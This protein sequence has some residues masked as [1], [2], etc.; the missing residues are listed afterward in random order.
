MLVDLKKKLKKIKLV[1][2]DFDG[3]LT[4][5]G[6]VIFREDGKESV[7]CS[8]RDSLGINMLQKNGIDVIVISK[9]IN[10]VVAKRCEKMKIKCWSGVNTG[11]NKLEILQSY[12]KERGFKVDEVCY[13]GDDVNDVPCL[14]WAGVGFTV[15]DGH[16][17]SKKAAQLVTKA[18]GGDGAVREVCEL[19]LKSQK[20]PISM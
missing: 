15:A 14:T 16:A 5:R 1:A 12:I 4:Y 19:I 11:D 3:V 17:L 18:K 2:L 20:K 8:R 13:G 6:F 10:G 9:E 7:I